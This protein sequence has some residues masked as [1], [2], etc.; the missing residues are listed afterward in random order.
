VRRIPNRSHL[1]TICTS[2]FI[3]TAVLAQTS[4]SADA[5]DTPADVRVQGDKSRP[6]LIF[7]CDR[8]TRDLDALFTPAL[9]S[10]LKELG[11]GV[12]LST[13]DLNLARAQVVRRLT[14]AGIPMLAWIVLPKEQGYYVNVGNA[15]QTAARFAEFDRWTSEYGLR[16]EAVGLDIEPILH[17]YGALTGDMRRLVSMV[18]RRAF[19]WERVRRAQ[20]DYRALVR[21]MQARGY[22]VQTHQLSFIADERKANSTLLQRIFGLVDV[23]GDEEVLMLY[24]S[25]SEPFGAALIWAYGAEAQV[26]A[27]GST[28]LSGDQALDAK[29]PPLTWEKFSRDLRVARHFSPVVG[30]YSLEGCVRQGFMPKLKTMDWSEP[31]VI[32]AASVEQATQFRAAVRAALWIASRLLY[33]VAAFLLVFAWLVR[34]FVRWR[35][36]RRAARRAR[37]QPEKPTGM[38]CVR[39]FSRLAATSLLAAERQRVMKR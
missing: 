21:R 32:S 5:R 39:C 31:V 24:T 16:W 37:L 15:A 25:L 34:V 23:R 33:L 14:D 35:R 9:V 12:A 17:E 2:A 11:A 3:A 18:V 20:A 1:R 26:V 10:D 6:Y 19:D 38:S 30:I 29:Y 27:V 28:N 13:E 8:Q 7:G 22:R 4:T 36:R